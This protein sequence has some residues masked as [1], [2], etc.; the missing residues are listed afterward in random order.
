MGAGES[1]YVRNQ[2]QFVRA[3][4]DIYKEVLSGYS[5]AQIDGKLRQ[6]YAGTDNHSRNEY[7]YINNRDWN[8]AVSY[9]SS[10]TSASSYHY[11][12]DY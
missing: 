7:S 6:Q 9:V 10:R 3:N 8:N 11:D 12:N 1:V 5:Q 2:E 4:R